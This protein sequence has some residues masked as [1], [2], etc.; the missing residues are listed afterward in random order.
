MAVMMGLAAA[1]AL[2]GLAALYSWWIVWCTDNVKKT[3]PAS[4]ATFAPLFIALW[5]GFAFE[6]GGIG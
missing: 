6:F 4:I 5:V 1:L 3:I 2:F